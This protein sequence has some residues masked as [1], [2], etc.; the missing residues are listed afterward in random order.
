M[1]RG[2]ERQRQMREGTPG[3][4]VFLTCVWERVQPWPSVGEV[5]PKGVCRASSR[6]SLWEAVRSVGSWTYPRPSESEAQGVDWE[7]VFQQAPGLE[8][9]RQAL[10]M[11][12]LPVTADCY[13]CYL[14]YPFWPSQT[15]AR[16]LLTL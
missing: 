5:V 10:G 12:R 7:L 8:S 2:L 13:E 9:R 11:G 15:A 3:F 16:C 4:Q 1:L 14:L 6:S